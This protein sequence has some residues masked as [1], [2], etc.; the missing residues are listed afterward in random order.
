VSLFNPLYL[1]RTPSPNTII[2]GIK[3]S[4]YERHLFHSNLLIGHST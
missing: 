2:L 3:G 4:A 1:G